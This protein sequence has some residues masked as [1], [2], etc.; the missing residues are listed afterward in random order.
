MKIELLE[1]PIW[2]ERIE[3]SIKFILDYRA[4][5]DKDME[6]KAA[7]YYDSRSPLRRWF[8]GPS[9]RTPDKRD[10]YVSWRYPCMSGWKRLERLRRMQNVLNDPLVGVVYLDDNDIDSIRKT[11]D[12]GI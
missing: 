1:K 5:K 2:I 7:A 6:D 10:L 3:A 9:T 11:G 8:F 4:K 12:V